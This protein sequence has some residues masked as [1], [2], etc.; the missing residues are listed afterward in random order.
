MTT[1]AEKCAELA[2]GLEAMPLM[3]SQTSAA[4]LRQLSKLL[5]QDGLTNARVREL[6]QKLMSDIRRE[7]YDVPVFVR[8]IAQEA[9][10][11]LLA[12]IA[13]LEAALAESRKQVLEEAASYIWGLEGSIDMDELPDIIR[14]L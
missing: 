5:G 2:A 3:Y 1:L 11:P 7:E 14:N 6:S 12:R 10:A 4:L 8:T 9:R 13:E